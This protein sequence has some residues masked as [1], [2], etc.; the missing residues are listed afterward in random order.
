MNNRRIEEELK[1]KYIL[2]FGIRIQLKKIF[3]FSL[4]LYSRV[5]FRIF[6]HVHIFK[7]ARENQTGI[8]LNISNKTWMLKFSPM[9][10]MKS[11]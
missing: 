9:K 4:F 10:V 1:P 2:A 11:K 8:M 6:K 3:T 5:V 7:V